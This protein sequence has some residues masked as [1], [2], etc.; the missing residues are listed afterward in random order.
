MPEK[1][2]RKKRKPTRMWDKY[3]NT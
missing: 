3:R 2:R 1:K